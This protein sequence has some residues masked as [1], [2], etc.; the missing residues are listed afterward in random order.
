MWA[1]RFDN[2]YPCNSDPEHRLTTFMSGCSRT[3]A[4]ILSNSSDDNLESMCL[5]VVC[6]TE[7]PGSSLKAW[8]PPNGACGAGVWPVGFALSFGSTFAFGRA[9][10][11]TGCCSFAAFGLTPFSLLF[12]RH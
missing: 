10:E 9:H 11:S 2:E 6:M 7:S 3:E 12:W 1:R 4:F 8:S 5:M